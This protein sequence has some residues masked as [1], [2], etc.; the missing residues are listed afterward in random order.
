[1]R[2]HNLYLSLPN[3]DKMLPFLSPEFERK[4]QR[5]VAIFLEIPEFHST[6]M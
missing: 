4:F 5:E 1:M 2:T 6:A 3:A